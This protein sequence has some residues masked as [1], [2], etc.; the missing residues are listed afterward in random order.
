MKPS[1]I[2]RALLEVERKFCSLAVEDL[3]ANTGQPPFKIVHA[4]PRCTI[5]DVYYDN[6]SRSLIK[7]G[8]WVRRR[9]GG[10]EAKV[11]KGGD[12]TNSMFEELSGPDLVRRCVKDVTGKE[13]SE[14]DFFGLDAIATIST[15][16]QSWIADGEFKIVLDAI[17]FG[18]TV[19]EVELQEDFHFS[20]TANTSEEHQIREKMT[21]MDK[22]I[23]VFMNR[24]HWA[25]RPGVP[26]GKLM[27][28]FELQ[29]AGKIR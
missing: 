2:V 29:E 28:Y 14:K 7:A 9:N 10:W 20:A 11:K 4:L 24:Y 1:H 26:K 12:F 22:R 5:H 21:E 23:E 25:F 17:D 6:P 16:R 19:G 15:A 27:A 8:I 13:T 3:V 18:H